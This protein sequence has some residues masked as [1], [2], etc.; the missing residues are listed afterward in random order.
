M[1]FDSNPRSHCHPY[2]LLHDGVSRCD[3]GFAE[4]HGIQVFGVEC[5]YVERCGLGA[6]WGIRSQS[7]LLYISVDSDGDFVFY[8]ESYGKYH[9]KN[10]ECSGAKEA[11]YGVGVCR[12]SVCYL[13]VCESN[14]VFELMN[15]GG[16]GS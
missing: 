12:E 11:V 2:R 10:H 15:I 14:K 9:S 4:L 3:I 5:E 1:P 8:S 16:I 13:L 7:I 6:L